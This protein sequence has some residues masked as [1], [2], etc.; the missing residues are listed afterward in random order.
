MD[1]QE[2]RLCKGHQLVGKSCAEA[3]NILVELTG[4]QLLSYSRMIEGKWQV[5]R[6]HVTKNIL[7]PEDYLIVLANKS[8]AART[9]TFLGTSQGRRA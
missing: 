7:Q 5:V 6:G 1:L 4:S 8:S 3:N 2:Y 9:T